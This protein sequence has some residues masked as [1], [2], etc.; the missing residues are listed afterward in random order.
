[1]QTDWWLFGATLFSGIIAAIATIIAVVYSNRKTRE[2]MTDQQKKH[3]KESKF[4]VIT[5]SLMLT[6]FVQ[7]LD[8]IVVSNDY[9]RALL[10]SGDDGFEFYDNPEKNANQRQRILAL[11]NKSSND[12]KNIVLS[13][14]TELC[15]TNTNKKI[16]YKTNNQTLLLRSNESVLIRLLNEDQFLAVCEMNK[17]GIGSDT[18]FNCLIEYET[19][20][21]QR[22]KYVYQVKIRDDKRIE[23]IKDGIES[24]TDLEE[25]TER[26]IK[27]TICRNLQDS[28]SSI[29]RSDYAWRKQGSAQLAAFLPAIQ[30]IQQQNSNKLKE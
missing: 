3:E 27:Q 12:I 28:I 7:L 8:K 20:A 14:T 17:N 10:F 4:V 21:K 23:V 25:T 19:M 22:I 9:C 6:S 26:E 11:Q 18:S 2:Q 24:I 13:T 16:I 1:M 5:P 15:N 30:E 29:D